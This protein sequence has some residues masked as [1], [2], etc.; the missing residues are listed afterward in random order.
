MQ[1][2]KPARESPR[3]CL[4]ILA[5][6][7]HV[8]THVP[9]RFNSRAVLAQG[10]PFI[11]RKKTDKWVE[12]VSVARGPGRN[13]PTSNRESS[14]GRGIRA[15]QFGRAHFFCLKFIERN[16]IFSL[17]P[18]SCSIFFDTCSKK[19]KWKLIREPRLTKEAIRLVDYLFG[20][21]GLSYGAGPLPLFFCNIYRKK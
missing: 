4:P 17:P 16:A 7:V 13:Q 8:S 18:L 12:G 3:Y 14:L 19:R 20:C 2:C 15:A 10:E 9:L 6:R 21:Q 1:N 11:N 5:H